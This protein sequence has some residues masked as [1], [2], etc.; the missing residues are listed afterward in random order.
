[1]AKKRK[2]QRKKQK[3][4]FG[5]SAELIGILLVLIGILGF[6]FGPIGEL[7]KEFAMF[8]TGEWWALLLV[9][10]LVMGVLM[11]FK[12]QLPNFFTSRLVGIYIAFIVLL[13]FTHYSFIKAYEPGEI[14]KHTM[15]GFQARVESMKN[16]TGAFSSGLS[17]ISIGGGII[18]A[19]FAYLFA[20]LFGIVGTIIVLVALAIFAIIL[21]FDVDFGAMFRSLK[22]GLDERRVADDD[23]DEEDE[24]PRK[25]RFKLFGG[26]KKYDDE[27]DE[28][29]DEIPNSMKGKV[30][31]TSPV[32][33]STELKQET[34]PVVE[35]EPVATKR[36]VYTLPSINLLDEI[37]YIDGINYFR[38]V[39]TTETVEEMKQII[40]LAKLKLE[41]DTL[42]KT[43]KGE[44]HTRGNFKKQLP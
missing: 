23:E 44:S 8:L 19:A 9:Y 12:R 3:Q 25:S 38:L 43:F 20:S 34:L 24:E 15:E 41:G 29:E 13:V 33:V 22:D 6:G 11:I 37:P 40:E 36:G 1:M 16:A 39:F 4:S 32:T 5:Y 28:L 35:P 42:T 26:K 31:V 2:T 10:T 18:G 14:M 21:I 30:N 17:S 27:E 7:I